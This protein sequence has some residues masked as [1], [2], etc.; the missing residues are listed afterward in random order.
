MNSKRP[1][2][3][4]KLFA[5]SVCLALVS[6]AADEVNFITFGD[7]GCGS[8]EQ[9]MVADGLAKYVKDSGVKFDAT[10]LLGDNF[11]TQLKGGA[12]DPLFQKWFE[13]MYDKSVLSMPFYAL[14][15]NHDCE[16]G[17]FSA[18]AE[19]EYA[20]K[21]PDRRWKMPARYYRVDFPADKPLVSVLMLDGN[22]DAKWKEQDPWLA[23]ELAKPRPKWL[24]AASHFP[25]WSN[26]NHGDALKLREKWGP[27]F[28][29][30]KVDL[31]LAGHEHNQQHLQIETNFTSW[32]VS[33]GGGKA[34][35]KMKR[36]DRGPYTRTT[37]GYA[38]IKLTADSAGVTF[39][40]EKGD[41]LHS[42]TR[43][44][45]GRV[46]ITKDGGLEKISAKD[47]ER[48]KK[49]GKVDNDK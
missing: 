19:L 1:L 37:L 30:H 6:R 9:K 43:T 33:G 15:G 5:V 20:Q 4:L 18:K 48:L 39:I 16:L 40:N 14:L 2:A 24:I 32:I 25:L 26:S 35:Y 45:E 10:L 36:D 8:P 11:Y 3:C 22:G 42:F 21:Y 13:D 17:G 41:V 49:E 27:L 12:D 44:P 7:F 46:T 23:A 28:E 31:Y 29:Q 47:M 34:L 38:H